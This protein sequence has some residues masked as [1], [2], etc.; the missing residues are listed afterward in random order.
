MTF[1]TNFPVRP[2]RASAAGGHA[3]ESCEGP[4]GLWREGVKVFV[5]GDWGEGAGGTGEVSHGHRAGSPAASIEV[6]LPLVTEDSPVTRL[7]PNPRAGGLMMG[8]FKR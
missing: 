8:V 7:R 1:R 3:G 6:L 4:A 2:D 5:S